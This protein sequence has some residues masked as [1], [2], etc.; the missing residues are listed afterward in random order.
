MEEAINNVLSG[1][2]FGEFVSACNAVLPFLSIDLQ[3]RFHKVLNA[4]LVQFGTNGAFKRL[5]NRTM[6]SII[7]ESDSI[8]PL[9]PEL[10]GEVDGVRYSLFDALTNPEKGSER[11][12]GNS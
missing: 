10:T 7:A 2:R 12:P 1:S 4:Y 5:N 3:D 8:S 6:A 9:T 11:K